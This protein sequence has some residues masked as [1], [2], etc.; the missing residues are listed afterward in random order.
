MRKSANVTKK[1][2]RLPLPNVE[3]REMELVDLPAVFELGQKLFTADKLPTLYRSWD[4]DEVIRLFGADWETCLVA[5]VEE[6][7]VGFALGSMMHSIW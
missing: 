4:E 1:R 2:K 3:I 5:E 6:R 7:I